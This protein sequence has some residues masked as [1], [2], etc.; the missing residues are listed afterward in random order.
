MGNQEALPLLTRHNIRLSLILLVHPVMPILHRLLCF[1]IHINAL[2]L[3]FRPHRSSN[4]VL[5]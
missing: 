3:H 2:Q 5:N 4:T 1:L